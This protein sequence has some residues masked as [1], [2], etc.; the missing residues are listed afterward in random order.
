MRKE[1]RKILRNACPAEV[2][3]QSVATPGE[4]VAFT[5]FSVDRG[6]T[7]CTVTATS[8]GSWVCSR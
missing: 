7:T 8:R 5:G 2:S 4:I 1:S 3:V 6:W